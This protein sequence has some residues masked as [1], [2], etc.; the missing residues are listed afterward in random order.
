MK[1]K[2]KERDVEDRAITRSFLDS[3]AGGFSHI[4]LV[5]LVFCCAFSIGAVFRY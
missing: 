2:K 3:S 5:L 1:F 4:L